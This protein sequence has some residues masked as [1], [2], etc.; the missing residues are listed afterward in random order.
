M[1]AKE[2]L[3]TAILK[4]MVS[5]NM[6][7]FGCLIYNFEIRIIDD[8]DILKKIK[9]DPNYKN[10]QLLTANVTIENKK[11][12]ITI[13]ESFIND[14][15]IPELI[16]VLL[17]EI[18][19]V[20]DKHVIQN[21]NYVNDIAFAF[22]TDHII[23]SNLIK[24]IKSHYLQNV[25]QPYDTF[26]IPELSNS[27]THTTVAAVYN[28]LVE[29]MSNIHK[30]NL[31]G[32]IDLISMRIN[33]TNYQLVTDVIKSEQKTNDESEEIVNNLQAEVRSIINNSNELIKG[34]IDGSAISNL[35]KQIIEIKVPWTYL[36][37][38]SICQK[39]IPDDSN[40]SW[41]AIKK[42]QFT[43]GLMYPS[44]D[45]LEKP[46]QLIICEDQSGSVS[47]D[48]LKKF[49]SVLLQS[50]KYFDEVR[51]IRHD[52]KVQRDITYEC[53]SV[54]EEQLLFETIGRGGTSHKLVFDRIEEAF[55]NDVDISLVILLTDFESNIT[56]IWKHYTWTKNIP[57]TVICNNVIN[58]PP[59]IDKHP[60]FI[61]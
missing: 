46:S 11:P 21:K 53:N 39:I 54:T 29:N 58:I 27:K 48:D 50:I 44:D 17:H 59:E 42:R 13:Y 30:T 20:L 16:F 2:K 15:E 45:E 32:D 57:V 25:S 35:I 49:S 1:T 18:F 47:N 43:L 52:T 14:H 31:N 26:I 4:I 6:R 10:N 8:S 19:H 51:I 61:K 22:A 23:N 41:K 9:E 36:L 55:E 24:D 60:I 5:N 12:I 3:E 34:D 7:L 33:N 38:K 37:D 40:K 56:Q 28:Y